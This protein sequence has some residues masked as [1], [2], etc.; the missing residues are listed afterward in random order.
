MCINERRSWGQ[1]IVTLLVSCH[2]SDSDGV[3]WQLQAAPIPSHDNKNKNK[4]SGDEVRE[5]VRSGIYIFKNG[6]LNMGL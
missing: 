4:W 3:T 6:Q 2:G 5:K 1:E